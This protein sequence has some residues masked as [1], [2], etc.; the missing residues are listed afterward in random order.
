M[1]QRQVSSTWKDAFE[2]E[3]LAFHENVT[4]GRRP[5]TSL[6]D[7]REDLVLFREMMSLIQGGSPAADMRE[8]VVARA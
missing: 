2:I 4:Q 7:A 1:A 8:R 6:A 5:K 3:W